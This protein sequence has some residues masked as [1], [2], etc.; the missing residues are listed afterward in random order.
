MSHIQE[1]C[2]LNGG[3][4]AVFRVPLC[5]RFSSYHFKTLNIDVEEVSWF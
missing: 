1:A 2:I 4:T 3:A 5:S